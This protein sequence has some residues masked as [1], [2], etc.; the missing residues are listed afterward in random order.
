[1]TVT[2]GGTDRP[3]VHPRVDPFWTA[4]GAAMAQVTGQ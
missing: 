4:F 2:E 1:M 3:L